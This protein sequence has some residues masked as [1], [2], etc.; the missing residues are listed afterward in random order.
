MS[1]WISVKDR[2]PD[3]D[4]DVLVYGGGRYNVAAHTSDNGNG[5]YHNGNYFIK[6][7]HW[8]ELPEPPKEG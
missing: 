5:W 6:A 3:D 4:T 2:M 8:R 7:T 1:E